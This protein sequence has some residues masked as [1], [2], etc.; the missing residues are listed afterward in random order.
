MRLFL[1]LGLVLA[2]FSC[3]PPAEEIENQSPFALLQWP[4]RWPV[5]QEVPFD[6]RGSDDIDGTLVFIEMNF[7]DGTPSQERR[8]GTFAHAYQSAGTYGFRLRIRDDAGA[9]SELTGNV[10]VVDRLE[11]A[12][13]SCELSCL[14][15]GVCAESGCY[16]Q[17]ESEGAVDEGL[18]HF[19]L[20]DLVGCEES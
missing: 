13:C 14:G 7:G 4:E 8:E 3:A 17:H 5:S 15:G 1:L 16:Q 6:A 9:E 2:A 12:Q 20:E 19:E 18:G 11:E 10:V